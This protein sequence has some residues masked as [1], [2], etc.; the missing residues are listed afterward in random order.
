MS[1]VL[2]PG[3]TIATFEAAAID[4]ETFDHEAHVYVAWLYLERW[5]LGEAIRRFCTALRRLTAKVGAEGKYHETISWFFMVQV[6]QRRAA[7]QQ[8]TWF[9]FRRDNADL[10]DGAGA[11]LS[12]YY[13]KELLASDLARQHFLL[14]DKLATMN[15]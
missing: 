8:P 14:P 2:T 10:I 7:M 9:V 12:R 6:D 4:A 13:S 3:V 15:L 11:L 1:A 5:P